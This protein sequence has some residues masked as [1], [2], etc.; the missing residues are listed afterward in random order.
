MSVVAPIPRVNALAHLSSLVEGIKIPELS[1]QRSQSDTEIYGIVTRILFSKT[2]AGLFQKS[3]LSQLLK[4]FL[5]CWL[6]RVVS[7]EHSGVMEAF[8]DDLQNG[9]HCPKDLFQQHFSSIEIEKSIK[10]LFSLDS[11]FLNSTLNS[12]IQNGLSQAEPRLLEILKTPSLLKVGN[13]QSLEEAIGSFF[14]QYLKSLTGHGSKEEGVFLRKLALF[15]EGGSIP[16]DWKNPPKNLTFFTELMEILSERIPLRYIAVESI[17]SICGD[18][19]EPSN[20]EV[21]LQWKVFRDHLLHC[22]IFHEILQA[23]TA[24][25]EDVENN[26]YIMLELRRTASGNSITDRVF[27]S[28]SPDNTKER[29][30]LIRYLKNHL[31]ICSK[32]MDSRFSSLAK[33]IKSRAITPFV[34]RQLKWFIQT[35]EQLQAD[36][37]E[38]TRGEFM[39]SI[40]QI[41]PDIYL[42]IALAKQMVLSFDRVLKFNSTAKEISSDFLLDAEMGQL[43]EQEEVQVY[44]FESI[45]SPVASPPPGSA[46]KLCRETPVSLEGFALLRQVL[47]NPS[48][49]INGAISQTISHLLLVADPNI[50]DHVLLAAQGIE[51]FCDLYIQGRYDLLGVCVH[52]YLLDCHVAVERYLETPKDTHSLITGG[53]KFQLDDQDLSFLKLHDQALLWTRYSC[54]FRKKQR[55]PKPVQWLDQLMK[56]PSKDSSKQI[57]AE[58]ISSFQGFL[59]F[60]GV[61]H[62]LIEQVL[63]QVVDSP[64]VEPV[65]SRIPTSLV[66]QIEAA[67]RNLVYVRG[68]PDGD[69]VE[70]L[71]EICT[72]LAWMSQATL[73][74]SHFSNPKWNFLLLRIELHMDKLFK[75]LFA[76]DCLLLDYGS[77]TSHHLKTYTDALRYDRHISTQES[78]LLTSINL[79]ISH[80]YMHLHKTEY[81]DY[82]RT[83]LEETKQCF[84][85]P[86]DFTIQTQRKNKHPLKSNLQKALELFTRYVPETLERI[87]ME[88]Q[89]RRDGAIRPSFTNSGASHR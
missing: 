4:D 82:L 14:A 27:Q 20:L 13:N 22:K 50:I 39:E 77:T 36:L 86:D 37:I 73:I 56:N 61:N 51:L 80:H 55:A 40:R 7:E 3:S 89:R 34:Q 41:F 53:E 12:I 5:I 24:A 72:Y 54:H 66:T 46:T 21:E 52:G 60:F 19:T 70:H 67:T 69:P 49:R 18:E 47:A 1:R 68:I 78:E 6:Q 17:P 57:V 10:Y 83:V 11:L 64:A 32:I 26:Q 84:S 15:L 88:E 79:G 8:C 76:A 29:N 9:D 58:V 23:L 28:L 44:S 2:P 65:I 25:D 16:C 63:Q 33:M 62:S 87:K 81:A 45:P 59:R 43:P 42:R 74:Q 85:M 30:R 75:H 48:S 71:G 31:P 38:L 35:L